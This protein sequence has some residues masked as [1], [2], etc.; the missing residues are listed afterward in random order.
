M[1]IEPRDPLVVR[2]GRPFSSSPGARALSLPFPLPQTLAGAIRTR[3]GLAQGLSF[4]E[5][6]V[7]VRQIGI[8]G[9]LLAERHDD[10]WRLMVPAP[11]D[12]V[13][14]AEGD[15]PHRYRLLPLSLGAGVRT[16]LPEG[17]NPVGIP[18]PSSKSKPLAVPRFW[19][20]S[21]FEEWLL[22]PPARSEH[23]REHLGHDGPVGE[24]RTHLKLDPATQT[25]E[26]GFLFQTSGLEFSRKIGGGSRR[27]ALALW[28]EGA[29]SGVY[30]LGGERRL[31]IWWEQTP[32]KPEPPLGLL[33]HLKLHRAARV[34][35]LTPAVFAAGYLPKERSLHGAKVEAVALGRVV[36]ASGWDLE[37]HHPKP[38]RRLVPAG[39]TYF[40]RFPGWNE[41]EVETWL[42]EVWMQN[43][44]N[45]PQDR[46]DGYG[47]AV[48]GSWTG[49]LEALEV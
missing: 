36:T 6:A 42:K 29:P 27:L 5:A 43:L 48:V 25:A 16:N 26:E 20:W 13:L 35:F 12:C 14:L 49:K 30:P 2:D 37:H 18:R 38:S 8:Q 39:S 7:Q 24:V 44:S 19:G 46:L 23:D 17:L 1:L 10:N 47:L 21:A 22:E 3:I 33:A 28:V 32:A 15:K 4:P 40:V 31:A 41:A 45:A 11:A 34:I 9:P